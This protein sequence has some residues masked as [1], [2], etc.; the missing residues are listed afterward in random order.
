MK[1]KACSALLLAALLAGSLTACGTSTASADTDASPSAA[2]AVIDSAF[3]ENGF[4]SE[5]TKTVAAETAS[6]EETTENEW[7]TDRDRNQTADL[8]VAET[9]TVEDGKDVELTA[10]GVYVLN[11]SAENVTITVNAGDE[12]KVQ[13]VLD[14]V[15]ITNDSAPCIYVKSA[16]KVFVTTAKS[17]N[18]LAVT[19]TFTADGDTNTDAVIFSKDDLVLNG[20]GTL[21]VSS[22][23]NGVSSKDDLKLTGGTLVIDCAADALEANDTIAVAEGDL[24]V[25]AGKDGLNAGDDEEDGTGNVYLAGGTFTVTAA[26]DAIHG[27]NTVRVD[28]GTLLLE[29]AEGIESTFVQLNDGSIAITAADDGINATRMSSAVDVAVEITG[30]DLTI[31]MG[32]GDTDAIDSNGSLTI[33]GGTVD[34]TARSPFDYDGTGTLSGGTV[35]VNGQEITELTGQMMGGMGGQ[36]GHGVGGFRNGGQPGF[37]RGQDPYSGDAD[38]GTGA[39]PDA[40]DDFGAYRYHG[41]GSQSGG[42]ETVPWGYGYSYEDEYDYND[43]YDYRYD[44]GYGTASEDASFL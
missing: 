15:S 34:I 4:G 19:G 16:D 29:A 43:L 3:S 12:D 11:G 9:I 23:E 38:A 17:E 24:T 30:G 20:L 42:Y 40:E 5:G 8:T 10:A 32:Q 13:L 18:S 28:G 6:L 14:G 37:N 44:D 22:T 21:T 7:F 36:M 41:R 39:T 27:N 33:S 35:T 26:S 2:Q 31:D 25:T 1:F